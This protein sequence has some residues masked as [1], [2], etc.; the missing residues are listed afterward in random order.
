MHTSNSATWWQSGF[1]S[2]CYFAGLISEADQPVRAGDVLIGVGSEFDLPPDGGCVV[3]NHK[4]LARQP[5]VRP[6]QSLSHYL[7]QVSPDVVNG[8]RCH[9]PQG[10]ASVQRIIVEDASLDT[11]LALLLFESL[12]VAGRIE[13]V[14]LNWVG[15]ATE[16]ERGRYADGPDKRLSPACLMA[17]LS[18]SL[19]PPRT[20]VGAHQ[21]SADSVVLQTDEAT[22]EAL[23][24]CLTLLH[25]YV[26]RFSDPAATQPMLDVP[27]YAQ[28]EAQLEFEYQQYL[29]AL[30]FGIQAQLS[31]PLAGSSRRVLVDALIFSDMELT[32]ALKVFARTDTERSW[33]GR[34]FTL[35]GIYRPGLAGTGDDMT[36]SLDPT[37][38]LTL[39][40]LW[41][42]LEALED[43]KWGSERPRQNPRVNIARYTDPSTGMPIEGAP[44]QPWYDEQGRYTLL[45][46]PRRLSKKE[47]GTRLDWHEDVLPALWSL[48]RPF[49]AE[50]AV[51]E[52][53]SKLDGAMPV[54]VV[55]WPRSDSSAA[56]RTPTLHRWLATCSVPLGGSARARH[57]GELVP[58]QEIHIAQLPGGDIVAHP[59]G[60]TLFDDWT[61]S[62]LDVTS[63]VNVALELG[64]LTNAYRQLLGGQEL[65]ELLAT[66]RQTLATVQ[67]LGYRRAAAFRRR[68][69]RIKSLLLDLEARETALP[70]GPGVAE[71]RAVLEKAWGMPETRHQLWSM[72]SRLD[73]LLSQHQVMAIQGQQFLYTAIVSMAGLF[74]VVRDMSGVVFN[75][76]TLNTFQ[77]QLP[78]A[79]KM[80]HDAEALK[81]ANTL[82]ALQHQLDEY[83]SLT[84]NTLSKLKT[85]AAL[86]EQQFDWAL[87]AMAIV[88]VL[89]TLWVALRYF[90]RPRWAVHRGPA[91]PNT[92][93]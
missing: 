68:V 27:A 5:G 67:S 30:K 78:W 52:A 12:M 77:V 18:H 32:G 87:Y 20:H 91:V 47:P 62:D 29:L 28:A 41:V 93:K 51:C 22:R 70:V 1:L 80:D 45:G 8:W 75:K 50:L 43:T 58:R 81:R 16:W 49:P 65:S 15:Y 71:L 63:L 83:A 66:Q 92:P 31:V 25:A 48:Y 13:Q 3:L 19:L 46:V 82:P 2:V 44:D 10:L 90:G 33:T 23:V 21:G 56:G 74:F 6:F 59:K 79:T 14:L 55:R 35:L 54:A 57:P 39:E 17:A 40:D 76:L 7:T 85:S 34:G 9:F 73:E 42:R 11:C 72:V 4:S 24:S 38:G 88:L 64:E 69:L 53:E 84:S 86:A 36:I 37:R 26:S 60:V 89:G 61:R